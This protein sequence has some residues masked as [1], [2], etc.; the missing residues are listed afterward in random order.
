MRGCVRA[1]ERSRRYALE[2][3]VCDERHAEKQ[4]RCDGGA[5]EL[6]GEEHRSDHRDGVR[7]D[8]RD[9][10][11]ELEHGGDCEPLRRRGR[12]RRT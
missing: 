5:K 10:V 2:G 11:G 1:G 4:L 8:A 3:G 9:V 12:E 6:D 7:V